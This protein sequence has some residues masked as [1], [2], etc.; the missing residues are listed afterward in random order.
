MLYRLIA[1]CVLLGAIIGCSDSGNE[2]IDER[3]PLVDVTVYGPRET[4]IVDPNIG[5]YQKGQK[6]GTVLGKEKTKIKGVRRNS[7]LTFKYM[8]RSARCRISE[9]SIILSFDRL[10]GELNA[11]PTEDV[12]DTIQI[13]EQKEKDQIKLLEKIPHA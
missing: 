9:S 10:S 8:F 6:L 2:Q 13:R 3:E 5:I 12:A 7:E 11:V 4:F 1:G